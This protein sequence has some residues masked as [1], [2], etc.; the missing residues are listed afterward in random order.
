ML[1]SMYPSNIACILSLP[2]TFWFYFTM[3][4]WQFMS[5]CSEHF[6][7]SVVGAGKAW[8]PGLKTRF[9]S[10]LNLFLW[11][12]PQIRSDQDKDVGIRY[13]IT[14][15]GADQPPSGIYNIDPISGN[16]FVTQ[17]LDREERASFHV[18]K[19]WVCLVCFRL[20]ISRLSRN[21]PRLFSSPSTFHSNTNVTCRNKTTSRSAFTGLAVLLIA[22]RYLHTSLFWL[23]FDAEARNEMMKALAK[24]TATSPCH[25]DWGLAAQSSAGWIEQ[26]ERDRI[27]VECRKTV[28]FVTSAFVYAA[29]AKCVHTC[30]CVHALDADWH[31]VWCVF[32]P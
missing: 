29:R 4:F 19:K 25:L 14:G 2:S 20:I 30:L 17:P 22:A 26:R 28:C 27:K 1:S 16:M 11:F 9:S 15:A 24:H 6:V 3:C 13:S 10:L 21:V 18:R 8:K 5:L 12:C 31:T 23:C 32:I 7:L